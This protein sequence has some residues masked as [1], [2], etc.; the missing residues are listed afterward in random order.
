MNK[1]IKTL[2]SLLLAFTMI[3]GISLPA[4]AADSV[5][6]YKGADG[7][8]VAPGSDYTSADLFDNFKNVMPGDELVQMVTFKNEATDSD[9]IKVYL[10][11]RV[12]DEDNPL[13]YK[14][15]VEQADGKDQSGPDQTGI[16]EQRDETV[17]TMQEFLSQLTMRIYNGENLIYNSAPDQAGALAD[18][19]LLG[20]LFTGEALDL[21]VELDVPRTLDNKYANRVGEV[22][23]M[24]LVEAFD[25]Q[26]LTVHKVWDDNGY[27]QRPDSVEVAL[28]RDGVIQE[29]VVLNEE[30]QWTYT[31]DQLEEATWGGQKYEWTVVELNTPEGYEVSYE[32]EDTTVWITNHK[33]YTPPKPVEDEE[34]TVRKKWS[35]DD[36]K[37]DLRPKSVIVTLYNGSEEVDKVTLSSANNWTHT[38]KGLDG[39]GDWSVLETGV[40]KGYV[41]SYRTS[42]DVV[43]ITNTATLIHTGQL[44]W[45]VYV[46]GISGLLLL[47]A[48]VY[49]ATRKRNEYA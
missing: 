45:P 37:R 12:H 13:T 9:Y 26:Q 7:S 40:P 33:D 29:T 5:I 42:G 3:L 35:G 15:D 24:F 31:W 17:A 47:I 11:A 10:Q 1:T 21:K 22:D 49:I 4:L 46:L 30:N 27:P 14:E 6:T 28:R 44:N 2:A 39:E 20:T 48:G 18:F 34:L 19:V 23:W 41:A 32:T 38:W 36:A 8:E 25:Y 43:T 16:D